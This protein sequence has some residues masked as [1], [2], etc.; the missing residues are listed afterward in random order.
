MEKSR[1]L[2]S[3]KFF[4]FYIAAARAFS[5]VAKSKHGRV[6]AL[7]SVQ[8]SNNECDRGST[9][10]IQR[11]DFL[12][13]FGVFTSGAIVSS[14]EPVHA[15]ATV[16]PSSSIY[17]SEEIKTLDFSLPSS[18][19]SINSLKADEKALGVIDAPEPTAAK[20]PKKKS[21]S[22]S[23]GNNP[24]GSVLP[25]MNKSG[26]KKSKPPKAAKEKAPKPQKAPSPPKKEEFETMD[27]ALPS[28]KDNVGGKE[29]SVF[30]L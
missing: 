8:P 24:M 3:L 14:V 9:K 13:L 18:Y 6:S 12:S 25:S 19:D 15:M 22:N 23:G 20:Q 27:F 30:A 17:L 28:Y 11:S 21:E 2:S 26:P 7:C 5:P 10:M 1:L 29:K 4:L 16:N